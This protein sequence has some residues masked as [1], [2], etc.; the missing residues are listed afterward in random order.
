MSPTPLEKAQRVLTLSGLQYRGHSIDFAWSGPDASRIARFDEILAGAEGVDPSLLQQARSCSVQ[1][2]DTAEPPVWVL[3]NNGSQLLCSVNQQVLSVGS[4]VRLDQGDEIEL[5][6]MRLVVSLEPSHDARRAVQTTPLAADASSPSHADFALTDLDALADISTLSEG[7]RYALKRSD[8][9]DLISLLP[10]ENALP[11]SP[12]RASFPA[13]PEPSLADAL[14]AGTV[15]ARGEKALDLLA[16]FSTSTKEPTHKQPAPLDPLDALHAQYL[17]KLRDPVHGDDHD[18]W[19]GIVR[20][21]P[22]KHADPV[23]HWM[24]AAGPSHSLDDLLGQT[25]SIASVM[26]GLD[27][28]G[29]VDVLAP[30]PFDSVMHLFAPEHLREHTPDSL[31]ALVQRSLPGLTRREHHSLSLD[32]AMPFTGGEDQPPPTLKQAK[33]P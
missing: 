27:T 28:L 4:K 25:H 17:A 13:A 26:E 6:L 18:L 30:E 21:G 23:Q 22:S 12:H 16:Q 19:N 3:I 29:A 9:G 20:G 15:S 1:R 33:K 11:S 5:G 31:E 24:Q 8:I 10:E 2:L 32:S 7:E 14:A